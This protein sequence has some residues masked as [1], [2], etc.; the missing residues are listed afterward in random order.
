LTRLDG[1]KAV[2]KQACPKTWTGEV[3]TKGGR[4]PDLKAWR[5]GFHETVGNAFAIRGVEATVEG[6]LLDH[7][8]QP[9]LQVSRTGELVRLAPLERKVQWDPQHKRAQPPTREEREAYQSLVAQWTEA[10]GSLS[11]VRIVGPLVEGKEG[12]LPTLEI[13]EFAWDR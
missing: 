10:K 8:G 3:Q 2:S 5:R 7:N 13:R 12:D 1:V 4:L 6:R 11:A 9:A